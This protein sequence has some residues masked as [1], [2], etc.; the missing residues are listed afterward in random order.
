MELGD[1]GKDLLRLGSTINGNTLITYWRVLPR[2]WK[3]RVENPIRGRNKPL[4]IPPA[5]KQGVTIA[6]CHKNYELMLNLQLGI[7]HSVERLTPTTSLDLKP[8]AFDPK[9]KVWTKFPQEGSKY[10]SPHASCDFRCKNYCPVV[11]R[12]LRKLF[13]VDLADYMISI[14]GNDALQELSSPGKSGSFFYL[15]YDDRYMIKTIKK[16]EVKFNTFTSF[17][18]TLVTKF[19]GFHCHGFFFPLKNCASSFTYLAK[20]HVRFVIMGNLFCSEYT[21]H[22]YK[23]EGEIDVTTTLKDLD[24]NYIFRLHK[25]WFQDFCRDCDFLEQ[26]RIMDYNML[27]GL[28]FHETSIL[29]PSTPSGEE[30]EAGPR[31]TR[32]DTGSIRL[33]IS[34]PVRAERTITRNEYEAQLKDSPNEFIPRFL[35]LHSFNIELL[36]EVGL[37]AIQ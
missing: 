35:V 27:V 32:V 37:Q 15:T 34:M 23:P 6:K 1:K 14:S 8:S 5:R 31:L 3:S 36:P 17:E 2:A 25:A 13:K 30:F 7:K 20:L 24:L 4:S 33:G 19:Y 9:E 29:E 18:N 28:H 10:T 12:S 26:E 21:I 22:R 16:A 11:F